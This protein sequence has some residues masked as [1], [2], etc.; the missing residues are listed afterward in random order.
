VNLADASADR[1]TLDSDLHAAATRTS[2]ASV[3]WLRLTPCP[4]RT[5]Y[6]AERHLLLRSPRASRRV[7][8]LFARLPP[9]RKPAIIDNAH[10]VQ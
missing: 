8:M 4:R 9:R 1:S 6:A 2:T 3:G 7:R 5:R 10:V